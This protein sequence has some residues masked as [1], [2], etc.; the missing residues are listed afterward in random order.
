[1]NRYKKKLIAGA[2]LTIG[3]GTFVMDKHVYADPGSSAD[4]EK[5]EAMKARP[6]LLS[7]IDKQ[8]ILYI[9]RQSGEKDSILDLIKQCNCFSDLSRPMILAYK[10]GLEE[11]TQEASETQVISYIASRFKLRESNVVD[12]IDRFQKYCNENPKDF[13]QDDSSPCTVERIRNLKNEK[14]LDEYKNQNKSISIEEFRKKALVWNEEDDLYG[15]FEEEDEHMQKVTEAHF[16]ARRKATLS[17]E[18]RDH[19]I[20]EELSNIPLDKRESIIQKYE[21][22][23]KE[24]LKW[25]VANLRGEDIIIEKE[26]NGIEISDKD[27]DNIF[28]EEFSKVT[29]EDIAN[30]PEN[31]DGKIEILEDKEKKIQNEFIG[32]IKISAEE[33]INAIE[34]DNFNRILQEELA[35]IEE[36]PQNIVDKI[37]E[38][39]KIKKKAGDL[40][41]LMLKHCEE[42]SPGANTL[43][44]ASNVQLSFNSKNTGKN[45]AKSWKKFCTMSQAT[46]VFSGGILKTEAKVE[47]QI[48]TRYTHYD[49][50]VDLFYNAGLITSAEANRLRNMPEKFAINELRSAYINS[51][52]CDYYVFSNLF[53]SWSK[54]ETAT[55][56]FG[57]V[58]IHLEISSSLENK[59]CACEPWAS[60]MM[61][62]IEHEVITRPF[63]KFKLK[64]FIQ[65]DNTCELYLEI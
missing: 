14:L 2:I 9:A 8:I 41:W 13:V 36:L 46:K 49:E 31:N 28:D 30:I 27:A 56:G 42:D 5:I 64:N 40:G 37:I 24:K 11:L 53:K 62:D 23:A 39:D 12:I 34:K 10:K 22:E 15:L 21:E 65:H 7:P 43:W 32:L 38:R 54:S 59:G 33:K 26:K 61:E 29:E 57:N 20:Q 60:Y 16:N 55:S 3:L 50:I 17:K 18:E 51:M 1:M 6:H 19:I 44:H 45:T 52:S 35:K 58:C 47:N 4:T 48:L 63:T 25:I